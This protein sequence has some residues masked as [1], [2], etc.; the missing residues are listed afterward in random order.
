ME[1][2][3]AA[4][5][6]KMKTVWTIDKFVD[7]DG[8]IAEITRAGGDVPRDSERYFGR[9]VV[10]DNVALNEGLQLLID[11]IIAADT[12]TSKLRWNA[13]NA[14]IGVGDSAT[15]EQATDTGL[16]GASKTYVG[17]DGTYPSRTGQTASW[18]STF[19]GAVGNHAWNEFTVANGVDNTF[20]NLNRKTFSKGTKA[21]GETWIL[22]VT[23]TWS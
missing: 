21:S 4:D 14:N 19:G 17:M 6:L 9:E 12:D 1:K 2:E 5:R 8:R 3:N 11:I 20:C 7:P 13:T 10:N 22:T 15:G 16:L 23:I 18:R